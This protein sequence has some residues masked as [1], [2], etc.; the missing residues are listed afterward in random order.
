MQ[1]ISAIINI[2]TNKIRPTFLNLHKEI[3]NITINLIFSEN[4]NLRLNDLVLQR[5]VF[6]LTLNLD[7]EEHISVVHHLE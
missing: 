1:S 3:F 7:Q 4:I 2:I 6:G 5:L